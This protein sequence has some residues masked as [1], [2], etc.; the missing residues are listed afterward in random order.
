MSLL[1]CSDGSDGDLFA[2]DQ[3][4]LQP[5]S[6]P[7]LPDIDVKQPRSHPGDRDALIL[8]DL[9]QRCRREVTSRIEHNT[10]A[11]CQGSPDF[12]RGRVECGRGGIEKDV[13]RR[14]R[15]EIVPRYETHRSPMFDH[16]ALGRA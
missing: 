7:P 15:D 10:G 16:D 2:P 3:Q 12:E 6:A 5:I 4:L 9:G 1:T 14:D 13:L 8:D 11:V